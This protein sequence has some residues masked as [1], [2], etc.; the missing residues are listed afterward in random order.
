MANQL[1]KFIS[2]RKVDDNT[3]LV[4]YQNLKTKENFEL[5]WSNVEERNF[6]DGKPTKIGKYDLERFVF[7]SN[8]TELEDIICD[9]ISECEGDLYESILEAFGS[10]DA[11]AEQEKFNN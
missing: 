4:T 7:N 5:L 2:T 11:E 1:I 9:A 10:T 6:D 8:S 3:L